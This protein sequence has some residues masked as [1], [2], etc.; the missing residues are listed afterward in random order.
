MSDQSILA[1]GFFFDRPSETAPE[2]VKGKISIK[3]D[4]AVPFLEEYANEKGYVN[5]DLLVSKEGKPYLK[6]NQWKPQSHEGA[7]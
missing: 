6:L 1:D 2:F 7:S 4:K 5:L 3:V